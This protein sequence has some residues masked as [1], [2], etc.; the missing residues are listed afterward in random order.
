MFLLREPAAALL[1]VPALLFA[2]WV[3]R[4]GYINLSPRRKAIALGVRL[5][6]L[7]AIVLALAGLSVRVGQG[8]EAVVFVADLSAS[9]AGNRSAV[10]TFINQAVQRR[11][12]D[13]VAGIVAVGRQALVEQPASALSGFGG[14]QSSVDP[15]A[16]NL[17]TGLEL[18]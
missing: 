3:W 4:H 16:T 1:L 6:L 17:E 8:R 7:L 18:G 9:D 11:P 12:G 2:L 10:Q 14:F 15:N 13:S 5:L